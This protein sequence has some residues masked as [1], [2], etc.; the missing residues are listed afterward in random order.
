MTL[1]DLKGSRKERNVFLSGKVRIVLAVELVAHIV[2][3]QLSIREI[4]MFFAMLQV[5]LEDEDGSMAEVCCMISDLIVASRHSTFDSLLLLQLVDRT[6][7][8]LVFL[9]ACLGTLAFTF[10]FRI[11]FGFLWWSNELSD[12]EFII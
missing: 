12:F 4:W 6:C 11:G 10:I 5:V 3:Q 1:R 8:D 9:F 7:S 2:L